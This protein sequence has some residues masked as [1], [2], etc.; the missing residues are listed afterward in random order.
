MELQKMFELQKVLDRRIETKHRLEHE[1]IFDKK[2]LALLVEIGELANETRCFK[3]W[4]EKGPSARETILEEYVD[5]MHFILSLGLMFGFDRLSGESVP[6][7]GRGTGDLTVKFLE[8]YD[9]VY[10]FQREKTAESYMALLETFYE[11]GE[12]LGFTREEIFR[13]YVSKNEVNHR[14]QEEGY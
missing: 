6:G 7:R 13:A 8:V 11:L 4:S 1:N 10:R 9:A 5:G 2:V 3:Y 14:R 12:L